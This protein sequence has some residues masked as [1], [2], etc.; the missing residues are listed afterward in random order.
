MPHV[1]LQLVFGVS[2]HAHFAR[3]R[4]IHER[5]V[6]HA[7]IRILDIVG[8]AIVMSFGGKFATG[9]VGPVSVT[10]ALL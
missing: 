6:T 1:T 2:L 10:R 7:R 9:R 3:L 8:G 5:A 4:R